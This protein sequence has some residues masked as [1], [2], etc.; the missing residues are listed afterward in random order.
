MTADLA[1]E[2]RGK[3]REI[4]PEIQNLRS[5]RNL[6]SPIKT[7][8]EN[9]DA[10]S[11]SSS[12]MDQISPIQKQS[13]SRAEKERI[14]TEDDAE[15]ELDEEEKLL[16]APNA[17]EEGQEVSEGNGSNSLFEDMDMEE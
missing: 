6:V 13:T 17:E 14:R 10:E 3:R 16:E 5:I 8:E 15:E 4:P 9:G 7:S 2:A 12:R 1:K 11:E